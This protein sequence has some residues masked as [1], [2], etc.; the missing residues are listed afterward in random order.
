MSETI[1]LK[2]GQEFVLLP[3]GNFKNDVQQIRQFKFK[4][5]FPIG[6]V[7]AAF[8]D[9]NAI[10]EITHHVDSKLVR[11]IYSDCASYKSISQDDA[12]IYTVELST[13]VVEREMRELRE[14]VATLEAA[15][16]QPEQ[17]PEPTEEE[18]EE[19]EKEAPEDDT[20]EEEGM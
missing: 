10:S 15:Q 6:E 9:E 17:E 11:A 1:E 3:M 16:T 5:E 18:P 13:N 7:Q 4:S 20:E 19:P 14:R 8:K 12:G 2:S